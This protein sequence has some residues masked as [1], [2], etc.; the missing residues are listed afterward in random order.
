MNGLFQKKGIKSDFVVSGE[1][2]DVGVN[3]REDNNKIIEKFKN[4]E[5][6]ILINVNILSEGSDIPQI[7]TV[8]L[9]RPTISNILMTQMVGRALR[10]L[11]LMVVQK[12]HTLYHLLIIGIIKF[13]GNVWVIYS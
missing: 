11:Q 7:Q 6:D 8:F 13:N 2:D 9:T 10:D 3:K 1:V 12:K 4:D 5:L